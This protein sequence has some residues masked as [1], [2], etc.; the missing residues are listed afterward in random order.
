MNSKKIL[1]D[2]VIFQ[3]QRNQPAGISRVWTSLLREIATTPLAKN[4]VLLDRDSSAPQIPGIRTRSI[5]EYPKIF[6]EQDALY[7]QDI[8][9]D[10][11]GDMLI[12][13]YYTYPENS[14][15]MIMLHDM[16][17]EIMGF[18]L[19]DPEWRSKSKAIEK[20]FAYF[21][22]SESTKEKFRKIYPQYN[23]KKIFIVPNAVSDVFRVREDEDVHRFKMM[24]GIK[25]PYF[26]YC[27]K[28]RGYK[29]ALLF[30][31]AFSLLDNKE[32]YE[33]L[34]TGSGKGLEK[35]FLPF[36]R[37][38]KYQIRFFTDQELS[39]AMGSAIALVYPSL[40]EG[41][42]LP[43]LEAN[44]S[45]C[46]VIT[47]RNSSLP[48]VGGDAALYVDGYDVSAMKNA[49]IR[50]QD[51]N[52]RSQMIRKGFENAKRYSWKKSSTLLVHSLQQVLQ[53]L[54]EVSPN[55]NDPI[56]T[57]LRM[58]YV[59]LKEPPHKKLGRAFANTL[60]IIRTQGLSTDFSEI[61]KEERVIKSQVNSK[62]FQLLE[63]TSQHEDCD[64]IIL[65]WYALALENK[66]RVEEAL[67]EC[68]RALKGGFPSIRI[69]YLAA[70]YAYELGKVI[71]ATK[72]FVDLV[73]FNPQFREAEAKLRQ[74][75][76]E[77]AEQEEDMQLR[78]LILPNHIYQPRASTYSREEVAITV[79]LPTKDRPE[80]LKDVLASLP[81]AMDDLPYEVLLYLGGKK[82]EDIEAVLSRYKVD[83]IFYD[84]EVFAPNEKFSWSKIM[85]HGFENAKGKWVMYGS[86][87][88]QIHPLAFKYALE[89]VE[90]DEE[91]GGITFLHRNTVED[92]NGI[93]KD[94]GFD[95]VG[96]K[97]FIN[98]GIVRKDAYVATNG[99]DEDYKFYWA[100]L[101][102]CLQLWDAGYKIIKSHFSLVEHN[103]IVDKFRVENSG[104]RYYSDT[105][106]Y[107][108]KWKGSRLFGNRNALGK[109]RFVM[110]EADAQKFIN[111]I[112]NYST[113]RDAVQDLDGEIVEETETPLV[114]VIV[115]TYKSE[116][117][118]RECLTDLVNQTIA[119]RLEIIVVDA[120]SP[121]NERAIVEEFKKEHNGIT[122]IRTDERIGVYAAWNIVVK[123]ARGEFITPF[124]TNDRLRED[125]YEI[126]V[127]ALEENPNVALV[128]GDTYI[129]E[130]PHETYENHTRVG[131]MLWPKY[132]YE[133]LK[134]NCRVGP[135]PMWRKSIHE[136]V[137]YF[138]EHLTAIGDYD[139]WIRI[140]K[141]HQMLHVPIFTGLYW[142]TPQSLS[143]DVEV[144]LPE[145]DEVRARYRDKQGWEKG[146]RWSESSELLNKTKKMLEEGNFDD[147][148]ET[149]R[150]AVEKAPDFPLA[151]LIFA[152][153]LA[154]RGDHF[155]SCKYLQEVINLAPDTWDARLLLI[156]ELINDNQLDRAANELAQLKAIL[157]DISHVKERET[158]L[159]AFGV[160]LKEV[161]DTTFPKQRLI[162]KRDTLNRNGQ[163]DIVI[164]VYGQ[165]KLLQQCV[166]SILRTQPNAHIIL[167]DDCSPGVEVEKLFDLWDDNPRITI[168]RTPTNQGFIEACNLGASLGKAPNI[169]FLNSD[170]EAIEPDWLDKLIPEEEDVAIV[171]AKLLY[172]PDVPGPL[173][174]TIQ[175][176]GIARWSAG[177][178]VG[179]YLPFQGQA[180]DLPEAN[181]PRFVNAVTGAC[182][183]IRRKVWEELGGWDSQFGRGVFE[184]VDLSWRARKN[185]Y[186]VLYQPTVCLYHR[187]S[188][189]IA[190]TGDHLL[191]KNWAN[192]FNKLIRK[193]PTW[194]NDEEIFYDHKTVQRWQ[195]CRKHIKRAHKFLAQ[196]NDK[197]GV[198][199]LNRSVKIAPDYHPGVLGYAQILAQQNEHGESAN[200]YKI[201]S[202]LMPAD[203]YIRMNLVKELALA[204]QYEQASDELETLRVMFPH[205][206][207]VK[208]LDVKH[209]S[210]SEKTI[211]LVQSAEKKIRPVDI[212]VPVYG[213]MA[214]FKR[215]VESILRTEPDAHLILV[216]DCTPGDEIAELFDHWKD[217]SR[218][219]MARTPTNQGFID[220]C[221]FGANLGEAPFIL[222][223]N[224]D[225]VAISPGWLDKLIP[226]EDNIAIVGAKLLYP[227]N[228]PGLLAG[229]I[230]HAGVARN[231]DGIPYHPYLGWDADTDDVNEQRFVNAVTGACFLIRRE[232]WDELGGWD[233]QFGRG[234]YEDVDLCWRARNAGYRVLYQP[235]ACL[236]HHSS[237]SISKNGRHLLYEKKSENL[238]KL[239]AKWKPIS[240]DERIFYGEKTARR[241]EKARKQMKRARS[242][243]ANKNIKV[244]AI[245]MK[246]AVEIAPDLADALTGHAQLLEAQGKY[247]QAA[248]F[249]E[250]ALEIAPA[251][252]ELRLRLVDVL[253]EAEK[254][255]SAARELQKL[256]IVFPTS[257][258]VV[259]R[260][261]ILKEYLLDN[262]S[263][264]LPVIPG[265]KGNGS[266]ER[267]EGTLRLLLEA[268]DLSSV[269][270]EHE[271][272]LD[273]HLLD[274][275][276]QNSEAARADGDQE[277]GEGLDDLAAYFEQVISNRQSVIGVPLK[278]NGQRSTAVES[279][280]MLLEADDLTAALQEH[281]EELDSDLLEL[282]RENAEAVRG[283]GDAELAEG[284]D[285]LAAYIE[286]VVRSRELASEP[287]SIP[288]TPRVD[289]ANP[290]QSPD[291]G[292]DT[293]SAFASS[294][295]PD[296][297]VDQPGTKSSKSKNRRRRRRK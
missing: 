226:Q 125:A 271:D 21:S 164:P 157:P 214:L 237:A 18:D 111:Q 136:Q 248:D 192:N 100:D 34:F 104:D 155:K 132:S 22:V 239:I 74:L 13:T 232:I 159:A 297:A 66:G 56:T 141:T 49:L 224:S 33:I 186:R 106:T 79:V 94:F 102:L 236:Y 70:N 86:D 25:K 207:Q 51:P 138:D 288:A 257:P 181:M 107:C 202:Q 223:L 20:S 137:G 189:S 219:T 59:L 120:A 134:D 280:E 78:R 27:G 251:L 225:T 220:A 170:I 261:G 17:P 24:Y 210:F 39:I 177:S 139:F 203:K 144:A 260:V 244:A 273:T 38:T 11:G 278:D 112:Q 242:A 142:R 103:N 228:T 168:A 277:L 80:G 57:G 15:C 259:K 85:N 152:K 73:R 31:R 131:A 61:E 92:F 41:F 235:E 284:L 19:A 274:L 208:E 5:G 101:D 118:I 96:G 9:D 71:T 173:G 55:E 90:G 171:G 262:D 140:G 213:Q 53:Q 294:S 123:N 165:P 99:F 296:I 255:E 198:A 174:G 133:D 7:L 188:A 249:F 6:F 91:V 126:L 275:V 153:L 121:E 175:H 154:T 35:L 229:S 52:L 285:D 172:P 211:I 263:E 72:L 245:A 270:Q 217:N 143:G 82:T 97:S 276:R 16:T 295:V 42:G 233:T 116:E 4:I 179:V 204:D 88:I 209:S 264:A 32:D 197:T 28:R 243:L 281:E 45:G 108:E 234:V 266:Q 199:E 180:C 54:H 76:K 286:Q 65:Y 84:H 64:S 36:V 267:A 182:F 216:D 291:A 178:Q 218:I 129:T 14:P 124:S 161:Q 26:F 10:E 238:E 200:W 158:K 176:A 222:F 256:R 81:G 151:L 163:C 12:S 169:L 184:D 145:I 44:K 272:K 50:V 231:S 268:D 279:L 95:T 62:M 290:Q 75:K 258:E 167:V 194:G 135:H 246:K 230:Q 122:Y 1:I 8:M 253:V 227:P 282:V 265:Q 48:E 269:L 119:D 98:F 40:H 128:Y 201:A 185:G 160:S 58:V 292:E 60:K 287:V 30:L 250:R 43:L 149:A 196:S 127:G 63:S 252:W 29:N 187:E 23:Y 146:K 206:P 193:W 221:K 67:K 3:T 215:C 68:L 241:W 109:K 147:A 89:M 47:C 114:S 37:G 254:H 195:I 162:E 115:S 83:K 93:Y 113:Q 110:D 130:T 2:G 283:N 240:S 183:L 46:P 148:F 87:D 247:D 289:G 166:Q 212:V 117:F 77:L 190:Q 150:K 191:D 105:K 205:D 293:V 156:D 69:V